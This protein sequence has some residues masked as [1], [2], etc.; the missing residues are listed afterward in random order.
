MRIGD[1]TRYFR[2]G[3]RRAVVTEI[4]SIIDTMRL[5]LHDWTGGSQFYDG[6]RYHKDDWTRCE[7]REPSDPVGRCNEGRSTHFQ[8]PRRIWEYAEN[9]RTA[10]LEL[11]KTSRQQAARLLQLARQ[12]EELAAEIET[13]RIQGQ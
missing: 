8:R 11:A 2:P 6:H 5:R 12:A 13:R 3:T 1:E 10:W 4:R 7:H 9:N